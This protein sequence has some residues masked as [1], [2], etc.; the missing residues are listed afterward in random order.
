M[1]TSSRHCKLPYGF[2]YKAGLSPNPTLPALTHIAAVVYKSGQVPTFGGIN[3]GVLI[4][5]EQIAASN[6]LLLVPLLSHVSNDLRKKKRVPW[7]LFVT[8]TA[9]GK[10]LEQA[11]GPT[12]PNKWR[13]SGESSWLLKNHVFVFCCFFL[14]NEVVLWI[15]FP[16]LC[17]SY[18]SYDLTHI[19]DHHLICCYGLHCKQAPIMDVTPTETNPLLA[20]LI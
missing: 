1:Q 17:L 4:N 6:A 13:Y 14:T 5:P 3:D 12:E 10:H 11:E 9:P 16:A 19:L 7:L 15:I 18:L 20:E 8:L 2:Y